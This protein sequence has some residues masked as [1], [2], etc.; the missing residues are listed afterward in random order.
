VCDG[1]SGFAFQPELGQPGEPAGVLLV[2]AI[3]GA[4]RDAQAVPIEIRVQKQEFR[5]M[6]EALS[7]KLGIAVRVK[8]S[9][10]ALNFFRKGLLAHIGDPG[11]IQID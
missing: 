7:E 10:P 11:E 4:I 8:K 2:R 5:F 1:D 3:L 9:L 6:L